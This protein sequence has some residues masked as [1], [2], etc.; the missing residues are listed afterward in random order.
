MIDPCS[1]CFRTC[2]PSKLVR[3]FG[4]CPTAN[5]NAR[6]DWVDIKATLSR[7]PFHKNILITR[8]MRGPI[9]Y[10]G[11]KVKIAGK[12]IELFPEHRTFVEVFGGGAQVLFRKKPS[13]VEVLAVC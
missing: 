9:P 4:F 10:V 13:L 11:G 7:A 1:G 5:L 3:L 6:F 12:I 8:Y 2:A